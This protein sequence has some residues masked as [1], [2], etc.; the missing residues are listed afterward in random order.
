MRF[1]TYTALGAP[2][3]LSPVLFVV[4]LCPVAFAQS[5]PAFEVA[6]IKPSTFG[7]R[8]WL[9]P[10]QGN[11]FTATS[12]TLK[13]L[14]VP[15]Y[16]TSNMPILGG[17]AWIETDRFDVTA[18][19]EASTLSRPDSLLML[20]T[21]LEDRFH[22]RVHRESREMPVYELLPAKTGLKLPGANPAVCMTFGID[23]P[24]GA[25]PA[26]EGC[27][28][29]MNVTPT[30]ID[31]HRI[32]MALFAAILGSITGRPVIDQTGFTG[33]FEVHLE[34]AP[35]ATGATPVDSP[36]PSL[37]TVIESQLGLRL[38]SR[39]APA[40]VLVIDYAEKPTEN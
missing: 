37:T 21:L 33:S 27:E 23:P 38:E 17:P 14:I 31:N 30:R 25:L 11:R 29:G 12:V 4:L 32:T 35:Y 9:A 20:Q 18:K 3:I 39:K 19:A 24:P 40:P 16:K 36:L 22:L 7:E 26:L 15:A 1:P 8:V 28:G 5:R 13:M 2:A 10:P 34:F 6:A